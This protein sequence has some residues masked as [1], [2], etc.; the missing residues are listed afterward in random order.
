LANY[1]T[2]L[3]TETDEYFAKKLIALKDKEELIIKWN[4]IIKLIE[5]FENDCYKSMPKNNFNKEFT[6]DINK[7]KVYKTLNAAEKRVKHASGC[8]YRNLTAIII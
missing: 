6:D 3:K 2:D 4:E 8:S 1:F 7:A 5:L